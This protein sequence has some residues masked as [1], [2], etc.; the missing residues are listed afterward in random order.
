[1]YNS[2]PDDHRILNV[3]PCA[4]GRPRR[5]P[6]LYVTPWASCWCNGLYPLIQS[7]NPPLLHSSPLAVLLMSSLDA[8]IPSTLMK[9]HCDAA[10]YH[11][12][13][14][15]LNALP[16]ELF[17]TPTSISQ[18]GLK[19]KDDSAHRP[20]L[21]GLVQDPVY[22]YSSVILLNLP[23]LVYIFIYLLFKSKYTV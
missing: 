4:T 11:F 20:R 22:S 9:T 5:S 16:T 3:V 8:E 19:P 21:Q 12:H 7:P 6:T 17:L 2:F 13:F 10:C 15:S 1:M 23:F 14:S 18:R